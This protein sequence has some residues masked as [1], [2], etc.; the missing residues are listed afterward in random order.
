MVHNETNGC[1]QYLQ[2]RQQHFDEDKHDADDDGSNGLGNRHA[3]EYHG[4][5]GD[6]DDK[7]DADDSVVSKRCDYED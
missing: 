1:G 6:D 4:V 7:V 2:L 3:I 5:G